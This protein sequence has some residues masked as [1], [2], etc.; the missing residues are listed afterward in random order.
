MAHPEWIPRLLRSI[1]R[2]TSSR[3]EAHD[4]VHELDHVR[5]L[6][7]DRGMPAIRPPYP[8][9]TGL[10]DAPTVVQNAE[11]QAHL[12]STRTDKRL[13][14]NIP[15]TLATGTYTL[16]IRRAYTQNNTIRKAIMPALVV[17]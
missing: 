5:A 11:T 7:G 10:W 3:E 17:P 6:A 14:F 1:S 4:L 2:R 13:T 12:A 8:A 15:A 9:T 16:E